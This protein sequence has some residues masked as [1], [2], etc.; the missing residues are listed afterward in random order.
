MKYLLDTNACVQALR[1]KGSPLLKHRLGQHPPGEVVLC[2]VVVGELL[3]G[4]ERS[5]DPARERALADAFAAQFVSLPFDDAAARIYA[6]TR[7]DLE[8]Q[9]LP[10]SE[11]DY[12]IAAVALANNLILVTHNTKEFSRVPG[13]SLE[14]WEIP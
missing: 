12:L 6:R 9:G 7:Y 1:R 13:L 5:A 4:A 8:S 14:D 3:Y 11:N 10:I 2:S